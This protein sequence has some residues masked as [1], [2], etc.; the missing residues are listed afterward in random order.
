[1]NLRTYARPPAPQDKCKHL[2][3]R[4]RWTLGRLTEAVEEAVDI[5]I[6]VV[7]EVESKRILE[8]AV[9]DTAGR[10]TITM[11]EAAVAPQAAITTRAMAT[12]IK[13]HV[14]EV[15]GAG[16]VWSSILALKQLLS[17]CLLTAASPGFLLLFPF[18][19]LGV[20]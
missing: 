17:F 13:A 12:L 3:E 20:I 9:V 11:P 6:E 10:R 19:T 4:C 2:L 8:E 7:D 14:V 16:E 15:T 1:M 18:P 5:H